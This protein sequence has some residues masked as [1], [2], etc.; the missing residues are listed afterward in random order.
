[1][2]PVF[3]HFCKLPLIW[4]IETYIPWAEYH[5][6]IRRLQNKVRFVHRGCR[7]GRDRMTINPTGDLSPCVCMD[8]PEAYIGNVRR[9]DIQDVFQKSPICKLLQDPAK[10][11]ICEE[12]PNLAKCGGG[13]RAAAF[14]LT[15]KLDAD[16]MSCPVWQLRSKK[17]TNAH[18]VQ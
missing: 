6:V 11:G 13:C 3:E 1:L 10:N 18:V 8:V 5:P 12:C 9:D 16:D 2:E 4:L 14:A 17:K 15:G 7:A